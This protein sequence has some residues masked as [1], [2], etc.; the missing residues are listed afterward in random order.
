MTPCEALEKKVLTEETT[1]LLQ[2]C[3]DTYGK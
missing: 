3:K 2:A 1:L